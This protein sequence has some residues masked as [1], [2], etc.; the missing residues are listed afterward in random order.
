MSVCLFGF[1]NSL[2]KRQTWPAP[3]KSF[4]AYKWTTCEGNFNQ[5]IF[6]N[7]PLPP[8]LSLSLPKTEQT[9]QNFRH[10]LLF[11]IFTLS[12]SQLDPYIGP[13]FEWDNKLLY[14]PRY[15][16]KPSVSEKWIK[17]CHT[18]RIPQHIHPSLLLE[19]ETPLTNRSHS[20]T[21][22]QLGGEGF[23][24]QIFKSMV[25]CSR[26]RE[27]CLGAR[28]VKANPDCTSK[29]TCSDELGVRKTFWKWNI[30]R[31]KCSYIQKIGYI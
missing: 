22:I 19:R 16:S 23:V 27:L 9:L 13:G 6:M 5:D 24:W 30:L 1:C 15:F 25:F 21:W 12:I 20:W 14:W 11:H 7:C 10:L 31:A 17:M 28:L 3:T 18:P 4:W 26:P 2:T 8:P 29:L